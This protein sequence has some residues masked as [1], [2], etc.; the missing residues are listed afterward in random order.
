M[1]QPAL[2]HCH[3]RAHA[4]ACTM[5]QLVRV[6][7]IFV[8]V[9]VCVCVCV[10]ESVCVCRQGRSSCWGEGS[11]ENCW[12]P[13]GAMKAIWWR[14]LNS[15]M[16]A[17]LYQNTLWTY[18]GKNESCV[19]IQ[20]VTDAEEFYHTHTHT[21]MSCRFRSEYVWLLPTLYI[22]YTEYVCRSL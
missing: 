5:A 1:T 12:W 19:G 11:S 21:N 16:H 3:K 18:T 20:N 8:W 10:C 4:C 7:V 17:I 9:C 2:L 14:Q 13:E 15:L 22:A 6:F